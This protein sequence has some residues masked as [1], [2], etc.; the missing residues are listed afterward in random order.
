MITIKPLVNPCGFYNMK[1]AAKALH[2]DRHTLYRYA[3]KGLI[4]FRARFFGKRPVTTGAEII[5]CWKTKYHTKSTKPLKH[6][7][8]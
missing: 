6:I 2:I 5:Q 3:G 7:H 4:Q 1:Q 8:V